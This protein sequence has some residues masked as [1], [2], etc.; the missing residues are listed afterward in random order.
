MDEL[1]RIIKT[2]REWGS[3]QKEPLVYYG[4][5]GNLVHICT[6]SRAT[7]ENLIREAFRSWP[8]FSGYQEYPVPDPKALFNFSAARRIYYAYE[9]LWEDSPYGNLRRELCLHVADWLEM[10]KSKVLPL[11]EEKFHD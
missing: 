11:F 2:L 7:A 3:G 6:L 4:I 1:N 10:N 5:C 8:K 9:N